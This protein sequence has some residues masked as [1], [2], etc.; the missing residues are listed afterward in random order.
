MKGAAMKARFIKIT[1]PE[2]EQIVKENVKRWS[3]ASPSEMEMETPLV[4]FEGAHEHDPSVYKRINIRELFELARRNP[5]TRA[6]FPLVQG[7]KLWSRGFI[8]NLKLK[9]WESAPRVSP[10]ELK[11]ES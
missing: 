11:E 3:L 1:S 5:R 7:S 6:R 4:L 10:E 2:A 8:G 9:V